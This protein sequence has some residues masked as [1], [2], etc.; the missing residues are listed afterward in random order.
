MVKELFQKMIE[1]KKLCEKLP[2]T[3]RRLEVL[4]ELCLA[5][6][7]GAFVEC[8]VYLGWSASVMINAADDK[9]RIYL[10][11][12]YQGFPEF[13]KEDVFPHTL[14][15]KGPAKL[16][17]MQKVIEFLKGIRISIDKVIFV[18]GFFNETLQDLAENIEDIAVLH[19][20]V[21]LYNS[22]KQVF[23]HLLSKVIRGG[24]IVLHDYP[25]FPGVKK[26]VEEFI[27]PKD[28]IKVDHETVYFVKK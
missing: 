7:K 18:R 16:A 2:I 1:I 10:C 14:N 23:D 6:P 5:A 9:R 21:D 24:Y 3:N 13:T 8:G 15:L 27:N 19:I 22:T 26:A 12:S 4:H 25:G 28:L 20:D 17:T 11:D